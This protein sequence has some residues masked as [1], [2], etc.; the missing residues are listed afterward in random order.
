MG[1]TNL[2][3]IAKD[4]LFS[5]GYQGLCND[6]KNCGC[7]LYNLCSCNKPSPTECLAAY[8]V[9]D[10]DDPGAIMLS[11]TP[12]EHKS[13][14][15]IISNKPKYDMVDHPNH[16]CHGSIET[17][18]YIHAI[19]GDEGL[20]RT[21]QSC[22]LRYASRLGEK[23]GNTVEMDLKKIRKYCD[24]LLE[25]LPDSILKYSGDGTHD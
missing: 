18:D 14:E 13:L 7:Y 4:W 1:C 23:P 21:C 12:E 6:V 15:E 2:K 25:K 17:I 24:I 19:V 9:A 3:Q 10:L 20:F 16:Y 5:R 22:I 8:E 11:T